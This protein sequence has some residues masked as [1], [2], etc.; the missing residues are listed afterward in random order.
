MAYGDQ[1]LTGGL[2]ND[3]LMPA[4]FTRENG[5]DFYRLVYG[6]KAALEIGLYDGYWYEL[7][8]AAG[9]AAIVQVRTEPGNPGHVQVPVSF[10][11]DPEKYGFKKVLGVLD[12]YP[13]G[14]EETPAAGFVPLEREVGFGEGSRR[15]LS[16]GVFSGSTMTAVGKLKRGSGTSELGPGMVPDG[17]ESGGFTLV[18][19]PAK[20]VSQVRDAR[21]EYYLRDIYGNELVLTDAVAAAGQ[22]PLLKNL[23]FAEAKAE[24]GTV[25]VTCGGEALNEGLDY[26]VYTKDGDILVQGVGEYAGSIV[27]DAD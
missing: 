27:L 22:E 19:L 18:R 12:F 1:Y 21:A 2:S 6:G 25:T 8:D 16:D 7:R 3:L 10:T 11:L 17:S 26:M 9:N 5:G 13:D 4:L 24:N 20:D 23:A 14:G 15:P